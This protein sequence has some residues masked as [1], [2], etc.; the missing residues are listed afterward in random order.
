MSTRNNLTLLG[1]KW[2]YTIY[3]SQQH[4]KFG[5]LYGIWWLHCT[6]S[7]CRQVKLNYFT[8]PYKLQ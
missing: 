2:Q 6:C 4:G 8:N 3:S 7:R 1:G 5:I